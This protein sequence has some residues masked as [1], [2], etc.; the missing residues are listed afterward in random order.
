[1]RKPQRLQVIMDNNGIERYV[2][3][4][5]SRDMVDIYYKKVNNEYV[6]KDYLFVNKNNIFDIIVLIDEDKDIK[7]ITIPYCFIE[8]KNCRDKN[9]KIRTLNG[10]L[11]GRSIINYIFANQIKDPESVKK[12]SGMNIQDGKYTEKGYSY[13]K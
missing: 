4:E 3:K 12:Y 10:N 11:A 7:Y 6:L 1:M 9:M 2:D 8:N 5:I 13:I